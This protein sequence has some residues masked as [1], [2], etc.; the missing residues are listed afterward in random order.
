MYE[1]T[2]LNVVWNYKSTGYSVRRSPRRHKK[3]D[4]QAGIGIKTEYRPIA[5]RLLKSYRILGFCRTQFENHWYTCLD[6]LSTN[7]AVINDGQNV[8]Y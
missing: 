6:W 7:S 3:D 8:R 2:W 5:F 1:D 4:F